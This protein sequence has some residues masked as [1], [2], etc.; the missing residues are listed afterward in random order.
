MMQYNNIRFA[1]YVASVH[2]LLWSCI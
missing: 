2:L 1:Y